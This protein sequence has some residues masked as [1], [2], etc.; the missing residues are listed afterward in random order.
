MGILLTADTTFT[1]VAG[2]EL[3]ATGEFVD[4]QTTVVGTTLTFRHAG[5]ELEI[6]DLLIIQ[7]CGHITVFVMFSGDQSRTE[8]THDTGD[9]RADCFTSGNLFET[10]KNGIVVES[11]ALYHDI[12]TKL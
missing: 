10:A 4:G 3:T 9:I 12:F 5:L 8:S 6:A 1:A 11:T 2:D 7:H